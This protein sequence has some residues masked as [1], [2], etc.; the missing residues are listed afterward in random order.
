MPS[1]PTIKLCG[2]LVG[3]VWFQRTRAMKEMKTAKDL[4]LYNFK[5]NEGT[6][7][8]ELSVT[9]I[10]S[11]SIQSFSTWVARTTWPLAFKFKLL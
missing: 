7:K 5:D 9:K 11:L 8:I 4:W 1:N 10:V 3:N 2:K 6:Q